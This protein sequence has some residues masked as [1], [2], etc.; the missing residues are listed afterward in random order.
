MR[1][2]GT[3]AQF[4]ENGGFYFSV[5]YF[6]RPGYGTWLNKGECQQ[7]KLSGYKEGEE[8]KEKENQK[9]H[10]AIWVQKSESS[11]VPESE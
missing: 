10:I 7:S 4:P 9:Y 8:F 11:F 6:G 5:E 3:V 2:H 1:K